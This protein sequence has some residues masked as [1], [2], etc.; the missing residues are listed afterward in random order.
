MARMFGT[1]GVRGVA[2]EELTGELA[3]RIGRAGANVLTMELI[4]PPFWW[5]GIPVFLEICWKRRWWR[6]SLHRGHGGAGRSAPD[7]GGGPSYSAL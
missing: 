7:T 4:S 2:N 3:Y 1:D 5:D 6:R